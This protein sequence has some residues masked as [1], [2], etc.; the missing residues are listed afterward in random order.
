ML[1][2]FTEV[3]W[4]SRVQHENLAYLLAT[5]HLVIHQQDGNNQGAGRYGH[6]TNITYEKFVERYGFI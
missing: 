5:M 1:F 4:M 3:S 2:T 6:I